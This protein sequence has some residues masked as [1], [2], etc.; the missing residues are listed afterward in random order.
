[1]TSVDVEKSYS[2][3]GEG[4][5]TENEKNDDGKLKLSSFDV[6]NLPANPYA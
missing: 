6:V 2:E 3:P 5:H 1:M 4:S